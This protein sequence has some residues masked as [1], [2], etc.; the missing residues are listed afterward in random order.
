[1]KNKTW[2]K[3]IRKK[4][5]HLHLFEKKDV[6]IIKFGKNNKKEEKCLIGRFYL[7]SKGNK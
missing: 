2:I 3:K 4:M 1:M 6:F 5:L 7:F